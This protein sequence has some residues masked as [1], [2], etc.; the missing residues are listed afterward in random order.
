MKQKKNI[1]FLFKFKK[2]NFK[3]FLPNSILPIAKLA[4]DLN[5]VKFNL[6]SPN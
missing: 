3:N 6:E 2:K 1:K 5:Y 4:L